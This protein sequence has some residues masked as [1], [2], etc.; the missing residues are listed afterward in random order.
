MNQGAPVTLAMKRQVGENIPGVG[1]NHI[2][3]VALNDLTQGPNHA[4]V[5]K[6]G[7]ER[8][9]FCR[10]EGRQNPLPTGQAVNRHPVRLFQGGR[11]RDVGRGD[12]HFVAL[13]HQL[14]AKELD[15][16]LKAADEGG[17]EVGELEDP[18]LLVSFLSADKGLGTEHSASESQLWRA[19]FGQI[20]PYKVTIDRFRWALE[21]F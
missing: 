17:I 7:M 6:S 18:Q 4:G 21:T 12:N 9:P 2:G 5:G 8:P 3:L 13:R 16:P 14:A 20:D 11:A 10:I 19:G 15:V 1:V